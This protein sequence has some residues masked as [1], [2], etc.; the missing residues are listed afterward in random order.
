[1]DEEIDTGESV[2]SEQTQDSTLEMETDSQPSAEELQEQLRK[3]TELAEN[4]RIRAEKAEK[5]AKAAKTTTP[6]AGEPRNEA[7]EPSA[8]DVYA[9]MEAKVPQD[10]I[11]DVMEYAKFKGISISEALKSPIVKATLAQNADF[12]KTAA[13]SNTGPSRSSVGQVSNET[14]LRSA[15]SGKMPDDVNALAA[16]RLAQQKALRNK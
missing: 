6:T 9:L 4:Q 13:A 10:D 7:K 11:K 16:A 12:R 15:S 14:L 2:A 3:A 5:A 8:L 1:M